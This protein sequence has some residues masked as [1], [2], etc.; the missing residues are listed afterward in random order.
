MPFAPATGV[1]A[2]WVIA[3]GLVSIEGVPL[4]ASAEPSDAV[5]SH[6]YGGPAVAIDAGSA[7][8]ILWGLA[9]PDGT[10]IVPGALGFALGAPINHLAHGRPGPAALSFAARVAAGALAW[11]ALDNHVLSCDAPPCH[12]PAGPLTLA[13]VLVMGVMVA[14]DALLARERGSAP[15]ATLTPNVLVGPG[16]AAVSLGG[17][18]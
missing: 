14:D 15:S 8:L 11:P 12:A 1:L 6:W 17:R 18:F 13:A 2:F 16:M 3:A 10:P 5:E 7:A 4:P 9:S